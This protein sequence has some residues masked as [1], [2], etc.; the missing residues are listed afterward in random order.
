[1]LI[2]PLLF[3]ID[4]GNVSRA[5]KTENIFPVEEEF[6]A[7]LKSFSVFPNP[8]EKSQREITLGFDDFEKGKEIQMSLFDL[9]GRQVS[10]H[11][12]KVDT[13]QKTIAIP[14]LSSGFYVIT[15][16]E[17]NNHYSTKLLVK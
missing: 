6:E 10:Q 12:F 7:T 16:N 13:D 5:A 9:Q 3:I 15:I 8:I 4:P 1:L 14:Q 2:N 11:S 17:K